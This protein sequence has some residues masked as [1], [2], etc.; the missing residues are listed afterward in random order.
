MQNKKLIFKENTDKFFVYRWTNKFNGKEYLGSTTNAKRRLSRYFDLN[1]LKLANMPIYKAILK[2]GHSNFIF[3]IIEYCELSN[4]IEREQYYLDN[5]DFEYNVLAKADSLLGFKHSVETLSW[6]KM[7]GRSNALGYKHNLE[8][9]ELLKKNQ[10]SKKHSIE[11]LQKMRDIWSERKALTKLKDQNI[12]PLSENP[13]INTKTK[14]KI[15]NVTNIETNIITQ[16]NSLTEAASALNIQRSTLRNYIK[17]KTILTL[18]KGPLKEK[19]LI[20]LADS[21]L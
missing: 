10:T 16:Y 9:L 8:T 11:A 21:N 7:K 19:F 1:S 13:D 6:E 3:D 20:S 17:N 12:V 5:F 14:G 4:T 18:I 2:Y 15:V